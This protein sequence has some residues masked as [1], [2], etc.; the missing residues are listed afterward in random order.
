[1]TARAGAVGPNG[2][3]FAIVGHL[4]E[5]TS[6]GT[7]QDALAVSFDAVHTELFGEKLNDIL[8][9]DPDVL[10]PYA[11]HLVFGGVTSYNPL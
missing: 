8:T 7:F 1:M 10:Q 6:A 11:A 4:V 5:F 2:P 9:W 3:A